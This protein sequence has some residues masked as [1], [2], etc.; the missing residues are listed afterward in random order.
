[1]RDVAKFGVG[2]TRSTEGHRVTAIWLW[3]ATREGVFDDSVRFWLRCT[4]N[5]GVSAWPRRGRDAQPHP[6]L[7][8]V[9][10]PEALAD[11]HRVEGVR[12]D[13]A[14][15]RQPLGRG[16]RHHLHVHVHHEGDVG[17]TVR[18]EQVRDLP[19]THPDGAGLRRPDDV[20][21]ALVEVVEQVADVGVAV[22]VPK[23]LVLVVRLGER[24][25]GDEIGQLGAAVNDDGLA[26]AAGRKRFRLGDV[27]LELVE[28]QAGLGRG[29]RPQGEDDAV[30]E[31]VQLQGLEQ[32]VFGAVEVNQRR[33]RGGEAEAGLAALPD[34]SCPT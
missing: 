4:L 21:P 3:M 29:D 11:Q 15:E 14:V 1:M 6:E 30:A 26:G 7:P 12:P 25:E 8:P 33:L 24:D 17:V 5:H 23:R 22:G 32:P 9:Q 28:R 13:D 27:L 31:D 34:A 20:E 2:F 10:V 18:L 19:V 16:L